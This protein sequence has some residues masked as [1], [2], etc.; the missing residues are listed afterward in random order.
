MLSLNYIREHQQEV[1]DRLAIKNFDGETIISSI[2]D[3]DNQRRE[4]QK[5]LDDIQARSN[6]IAKEIGTFFQSGR[7]AEKHFKGAGHK[8]GIHKDSIG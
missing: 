7:V 8:A 6:Q 3:L 5:Q 2:V 1:I 4:T